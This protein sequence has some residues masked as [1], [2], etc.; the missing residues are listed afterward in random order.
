MERIDDEL[1]IEFEPKNK[2]RAKRRKESARARNR[3]HRKRDDLKKA[4]KIKRIIKNGHLIDGRVEDIPKFSYKDL[5]KFE[6]MD[7]EA[8]D[9]WDERDEFEEQKKTK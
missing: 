9:Y 1:D 6:K 8:R 4:N 5:R 2:S 7:E 3:R